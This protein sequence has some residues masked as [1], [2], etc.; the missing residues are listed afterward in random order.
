[1]TVTVP[2]KESLRRGREQVQGTHAVRVGVPLRMLQKRHALTGASPVWR[3][4]ER[5]QQRNISVELEP[6]HPCWIV[7]RPREEEMLA[8]FGR[9]VPGR[10][11]G[12]LQERD[13]GGEGRPN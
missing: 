1:M 3:H 12:C 7:G 4:D 2:R 13:G 9:Q 11:T 5:T 8:V 6:H 10:K